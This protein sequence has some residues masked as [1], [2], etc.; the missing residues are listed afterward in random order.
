[1][2][3]SHLSL[4]E[5]ILLSLSSLI[6]EHEIKLLASIVGHEPLKD[7]LD[8]VDKDQVA[9]VHL[10]NGRKVYQVAGSSTNYTVH[11]E[12]A[13]GGYCPCPAYSQNIVAGRG[14]QI[15]CKHLL[16]CRIAD[17]VSQGWN[18]KKVSNKWIAGYATKFGTAVPEGLKGK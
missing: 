16:A 1:M 15:I 17:K 4:L 12:L 9:R 13:G 3:D 7:A 18:E 14:N 6:T 11:P 8:L 10:P 2:T 5:G